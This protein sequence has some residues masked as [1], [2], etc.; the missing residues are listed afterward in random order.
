MSYPSA[1][2]LVYAPGQQR[3]FVG[4]GG[5]ED[6]ER[7]DVFAVVGHFQGGEGVVCRWFCC[8]FARVTWFHFLLIRGW[9][10]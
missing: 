4:D 10:L 3:V 5:W 2:L 8:R 1:R 6:C 9:A 7:N